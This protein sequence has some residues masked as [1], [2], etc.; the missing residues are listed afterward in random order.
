MIKFSST[1]KEFKQATVALKF[2]QNNIPK[3]FSAA[4]NRVAQGVRTEAVKKVREI[5]HVKAGD[6]RQTIRI[7]KASAARLEMIFTSRGPSIPLIKFKTTP[8]KAPRKQPRV[9]RAAVKKKSGKK[10][11]PGA[12]VAEMRSGHLG[13]FERAGKKR[14]PINQLFG[15]AIPVMLSEPGVAEHL[16]TEA[17]RRMAE[18]IDHEVG[19]VLGRM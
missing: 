1:R 13:V 2:V 14:T 12:F 17:Q 8:S 9:L 3:A 6:V 18:R 15:P 11:I 7:T 16:Q 10:P 4:M 5:Y 19:R